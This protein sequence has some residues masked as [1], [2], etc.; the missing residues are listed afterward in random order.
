MTEH[1]DIQDSQAQA[2]RFSIDHTWAQRT[3]P[4]QVR[5]GIS[6]Y[7]ADAL[8]EIVFAK[9]PEPGT[10]IDEGSELAFVESA[11]SV[12]DIYS[13]ISG[14]LATINPAIST[15]PDCIGKSPEADGWLCELQTEEA[16]EGLMSHSEYVAYVDG[17]VEGFDPGESDTP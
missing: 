2:P 17:S 3:S 7:L 1:S 6:Q 10:A 8:G 13:P 15:S 4:T 5:V 14:T 12:S 9:L 16:L 11:K